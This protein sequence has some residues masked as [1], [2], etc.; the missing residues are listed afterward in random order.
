MPKIK[1]PKCEHEFKMTKAELF[2]PKVMV[3]TNGKEIAEIIEVFAGI[4]P[5]INYGHKGFR[6]DAQELIEKLGFEKA[7]N[8]AKFAVDIQGQQF[9]PTITTPTQLRYK[10]GDLIAYYKKNSQGRT[11]HI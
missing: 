2:P 10:L 4:N 9:A 5:T 6:S 7:L 11:V 8:T 1:C 3:G